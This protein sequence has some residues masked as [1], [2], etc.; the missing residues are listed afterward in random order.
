[1]GSLRG[2]ARPPE[3]SLRGLARPRATGRKG[4]RLS[5]ACGGRNA[6]LLISW[7]PRAMGPVLLPVSSV[8]CYQVVTVQPQSGEA[9]GRGP[10]RGRG[11]AA[12]ACTWKVI[13]WSDSQPGSRRN[14]G[15]W[16]FW[17]VRGLLGGVGFNWQ[18]GSLATRAGGRVGLAEEG[19]LVRRKQGGVGFLSSHTSKPEEA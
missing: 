12:V 15:D 13:G 16:G 3:G 11:P 14:G 19:K 10:R 8:V 2:L 7:R 6:P 9:R 18:L 5:S 1:M 17:V 4:G